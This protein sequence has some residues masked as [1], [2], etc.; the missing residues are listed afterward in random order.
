LDPLIDLQS[1][2]IL[3]SIDQLPKQGPAAPWRVHQ[4]YPRDRYLLRHGPLEDQGIRFSRV[5]ARS[6]V[7]SPSPRD[8]VPAPSPTPG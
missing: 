6:S 7:R 4:N 1:G 8:A 5:P 3:R 2:Y